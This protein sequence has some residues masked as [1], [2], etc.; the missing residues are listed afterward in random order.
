MVNYW[1]KL[2]GKIMEHAIEIKDTK[3]IQICDEIIKVPREV[4]SA[5]LYAYINRC[6]EVYQIAFF[7][8]RVLYPSRLKNNEKEKQDLISK[9]INYTYFKER[10]KYSMKPLD[11]TISHSKLPRNF[12]KN[13]S[14]FIEKAD[15]KYNINTFD[16][17]GWVDPFPNEQYF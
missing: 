9:R 1:D 13:Y 12:K 8:W 4:Q 17:L 14:H 3:M 15:K 6:R 10:G 2:L 16:Q 7:Q 11:Q 5:T